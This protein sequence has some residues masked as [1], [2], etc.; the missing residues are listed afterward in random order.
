VAVEPKTTADQDKMGNALH[1]LSEEDPTFRVRSD[2]TTG[3]T[4]ISGMGEL[5]L[6]ILV[7]RMLREFKV[8]AT[9]G[10]PRVA[11][12]ESIT[13]TVDHL[14]YRHVKQSGGRG[15]FAHVVI[16]LEPG[17]PG[18]G[19]GFES[20]IVGGAIPRE[21]ISPVER[22][23]RGAAENGVL[24]GYPVTDVMVTLIDGSFH[25]V[26]SSEMAFQLAGSMAFKEG[27]LKAKPVLLEP[28]M[29]VEVLMPEEYMGDIMG[30]ISSRRGAIQ[31]MEGRPGN[32]QAVLAI[33]PLAEMFGYATVLRS[34]TQGRGVFSMEFSRYERVPEAIALEVIKAK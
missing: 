25:D 28:L 6:E 24:A 23:V 26:D 22:G 16:K 17:V 5:H 13:R 29:K 30:D 18:S 12:N 34:R 20:A 31:G 8:Q 9:V 7:D 2:E 32:A 11:Y 33:V 19:I 15:Q 3:Q 21:F 1:K 27:V 14:D 4:V 10:R